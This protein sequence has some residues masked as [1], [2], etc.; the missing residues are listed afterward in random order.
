MGRVHKP[1]S[2]FCVYCLSVFSPTLLIGQQVATPSF[3]SSQ[4][5]QST[6]APPGTASSSAVVEAEKQL[7][8]ARKQ[9]NDA[10]KLSQNL[11]LS[12]QTVA[13]LK[14]EMSLAELRLRQARLSEADIPETHKLVLRRDLDTALAE[15]KVHFASSVYET[16]KKLYSRGASSRQEVKRALY[17]LKISKFE[18][19]RAK[20]NA[21]ELT[22]EVKKKQLGLLQV[23][24]AKL[25]YGEAIANYEMMKRLY[26]KSS[27]S[28]QRLLYS[29]YLAK[30]A[31]IQ[32]A[33]AKVEASDRSEV[34][35]RFNLI[36]LALEQAKAKNRFVK[37][38]HEANKALFEKGRISKQEFLRSQQALQKS[39][40][41]LE[42]AKAA[43]I[44]EIET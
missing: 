20:I 42:A 29:H 31:K 1:G 30:N 35:K 43:A 24:L 22:D 5:L 6:D 7:E 10:V 13:R 38:V 21:S 17:S 9:Y 26:Q 36:D 23:A 12:S 3:S 16:A 8:Q 39:D 32:L 25:D 15:S 2:L 41:E 37:T 40:L 4:E 18:L 27:V 14:Y 34:E 33:A 28:K 44:S 19:R 11:A